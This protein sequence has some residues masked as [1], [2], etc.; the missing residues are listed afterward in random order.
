MAITTPL[1]DDV[2]L[3]RGFSAHEEIS[4]LFEFDLDL[5]SE[6]KE[7]DFNDIIG[8]NVTIR[9]ELPEGGQ[10]FW[11][12]FINRFVQD[13]SPGLQF[14]QYRATMVPWL[15]FLTLT[16]DCRIFQDKTVPE[17]VTQIF[18]DL[19]F[20]DI[21]DRLSSSYRTW[22]YCVQYRETDFNFVSRLME[23]EGIYYYFYTKRVNAPSCFAIP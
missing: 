13:A 14:A 6:N 9:M 4:R 7:I 1:G 10:R 5:L 18:T 15:W 12:G 16:S 21:E 22:I 19:G 3:L 17:I 2:L 8:Q 20:S 23:Q 11:N